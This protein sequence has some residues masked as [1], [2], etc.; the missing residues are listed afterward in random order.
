MVNM[1]KEAITAHVRAL[2]GMHILTSVLCST[3]LPKH[4][5]CLLYLQKHSDQGNVQSAIHTH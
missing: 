3:K 4:S 1:E 2:K 5:V